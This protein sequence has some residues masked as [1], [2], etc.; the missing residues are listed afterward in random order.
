MSDGCSQGDGSHYFKSLRYSY[1]ICGDYHSENLDDRRKQIKLIV[2][3]VMSGAAGGELELT[4]LMVALKAKLG[5]DWIA[6]EDAA[7]WSKSKASMWYL[8]KIPKSD[9]SAS[10]LLYIYPSGSSSSS[11]K[12]LAIEGS[13]P[14]AIEG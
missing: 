13:K 8:V 7:E 1:D 9:G 11:S 2:Q 10:K 5:G 14:L 3:E 12:P 6:T 4:T